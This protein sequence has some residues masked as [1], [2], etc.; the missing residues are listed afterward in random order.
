MQ[1][2]F[3]TTS[4]HQFRFVTPTPAGHQLVSGCPM[5]LTVLLDARIHIVN[6]QY[7]N[8]KVFPYKCVTAVLRIIS[9]L[10]IE[11]IKFYT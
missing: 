8:T 10:E 5:I 2:K 3:L 6:R 4:D 7:W 9:S 11:T 1:I